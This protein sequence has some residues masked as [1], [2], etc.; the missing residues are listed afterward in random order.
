MRAAFVTV[1]GR[2]RRLEKACPPFRAGYQL[3]GHMSNPAI[4]VPDL[5][6]SS[7]TGTTCGLLI[8][9][10]PVTDRSSSTYPRAVRLQ[11]AYSRKFIVTTCM[12]CH[13]S[14]KANGL[15]T[16]KI[17]HVASFL[18]HS[19]VGVA[20][21]VFG[22]ESHMLLTDQQTQVNHHARLPKALP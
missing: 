7:Q 14:S 1:A 17:R 19:F 12:R 5:L 8:E 18:V 20:D 9:T 4:T 22:G 13:P 3:F 2:C 6:R 15:P 21:A 10:T 16:L 11:T